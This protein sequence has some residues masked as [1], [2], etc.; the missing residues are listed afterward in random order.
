MY[1]L[2]LLFTFSVLIYACQNTSDNSSKKAAAPETTN[3]KKI[4]K[5]Q[6]GD[7]LQ[8]IDFELYCEKQEP[9]KEA[10]YKL[11]IKTP[12][13]KEPVFIESLAT[14]TTVPKEDYRALQMLSNANG[15]VSAWA[16]G[17]GPLIYGYI[18]DDNEIVLMKAFQKEK[19]HAHEGHDHKGHEHNQKEID[20]TEFMRIVVKKDGTY[21]KKTR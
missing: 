15:A 4:M 9:A 12:L 3:D 2:L 16:K 11:F 1:R 8:P 7:F 17:G 5:D 21:E 19:L 18:E 14:C 13:L 6:L 20:Y 10:G